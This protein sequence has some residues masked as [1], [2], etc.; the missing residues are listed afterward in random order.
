MPG[1]RVVHYLVAAKSVAE[2]VWCWLQCGTLAKILPPPEA[3]ANGGL[4]MDSDDVEDATL[5][6]ID[7]MAAENQRR[8]ASYSASML[9][10]AADR[11]L[12]H[13]K[14]SQCIIRHRCADY[15]A[16]WLSIAFDI[17]VPLTVRRQAIVWQ[18]SLLCP[19]RRA[20]KISCGR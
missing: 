20:G 15:E 5:R 4:P 18:L 2:C 16:Q 3:I 1:K 8:C 6:T 9:M 14:R 17:R 19:L 12:Q 13:V 10:V 11:R 7:D